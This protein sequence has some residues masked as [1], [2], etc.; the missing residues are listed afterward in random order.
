M[1][2]NGPTVDDSGYVYIISGNG[3]VGTSGNP[4]DPLNRGESLLKFKPETDSLKLVD[5]FTPNNYD[6]LEEYDL[7]YGVGGVMLIPNSS[8]S[9]SGSKAGELFLLNNSH[10]GKYSAGNDSVIQMLPVV[11]QPNNPVGF[12][13]GTPVYYHYFSQSDT[14][15]IY[16][17]GPRDSLKQFFFDRVAG[18]FDLNKTIQGS[19][20]VS[21]SST[22]GPVLTVSS[23]GTNVGSGIVWVLRSGGGFGSAGLLEAYDARD[24]RHLLWNSNMGTASNKFGNLPK[25]NTAVVANGKVYVPSFSN[26]LYVYGLLSK[27]INTN[28]PSESFEVSF[29]KI[30]PNPAQNFIKI[31]YNLSRTLNSLT[32]QI[33]DI[34]GREIMNIPLNSRAGEHSQIVQLNSRIRAG[35]Y[36]VEYHSEDTVFGRA[37]FVKY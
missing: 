19:V 14:E 30:Y 12:N 36:F 22:Y 17:W 23:D 31:E 27:H 18:K 34:S 8:L 6:Y 21:Q 25:F 33:K 37:K 2:G 5:F 13:Y 11:P 35:I 24:I 32:L 10:L 7:D 29:N 28:I 26:K 9:V 3:T 20:G 16:V 1:A 4:N 15:C